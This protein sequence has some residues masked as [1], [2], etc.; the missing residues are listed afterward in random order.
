[1]RLLFIL[2]FSLQT[3]SGYFLIPIHSENRN[4]LAQIKLTPIGKF[5][6]LRKARTN[7]PA[8]YHTGIDI[9]RPNNNYSNEPIYPIANGTVISLRT[10]GPYANIIMEHEINNKKVWTVYEHIAG[11]A[12]DLHSHVDSHTPI[13]RFMNKE[14]LDKYGW[15]FDHFHLEILKFPPKPMKPDS[16]HP[17]RLFNSFTLVCYTTSDL[18]KYYFEPLCFLRDNSGY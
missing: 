8:H 3:F 15:Q 12:V 1:M 17:K 16:S 2:L 11:I 4:D 6:L 18:E 10:D 13:A 7:V 9:K 14:E 5:G